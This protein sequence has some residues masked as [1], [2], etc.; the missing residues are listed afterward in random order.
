[1]KKLIILVLMG[2][3]L[4]VGCN[5]LS[6]FP[7]EVEFKVT[8]SPTGK[9]FIGNYGNSSGIAT[10]GPETTPKTYTTQLK[11]KWDFAS[12]V[13]TKLDSGRWTLT[14]KV[15]VD[16]NLKDERSTTAEFGSV[17]LS[18]YGKD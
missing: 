1:M 10:V 6:N 12:G 18:V 4:F 5:K 2:T 7:K 3:F 13:F 14:V 15:Y 9:K 8:S 17:S 11:D 16:G